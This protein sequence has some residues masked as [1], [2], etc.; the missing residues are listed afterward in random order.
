MTR[1]RERLSDRRPA[2]TF[3]IAASGLRYR[4]TIGRYED[5]R[6]G[7]V[8]L[9]CGK[10]ES[11]ADTAARDSAVVASIALQ[12]GAPLDVIRRALMRDRHGNASGPLGIALDRVAAT[13]SST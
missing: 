5:G 2:E 13:E 6:I 9:T 8:F 3:E 12:F 4:A 10:A 7:E 11:A 1:E